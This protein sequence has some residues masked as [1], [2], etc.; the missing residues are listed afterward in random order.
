MERMYQ[1][2]YVFFHFRSMFHLYALWKSHKTSG[3][4]TFSGGVEI[5]HWPEWDYKHERF[6]PHLNFDQ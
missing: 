3:F 4:M 5:E 1:K 2:S 6:A